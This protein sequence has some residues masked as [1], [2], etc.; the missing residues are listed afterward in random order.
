MARINLTREEYTSGELPPVCVV[1]GEYTE[2]QQSHEF[3]S[4][5]F[6]L[7]L[8]CY[9]APWACWLVPFFC[10]FILLGV[11]QTT[12]AV[13]PVCGDHARYWYRRRLFILFLVTASWLFQIAAM[14]FAGQSPLDC[15][16]V[17]AGI[18]GSVVIFVISFLEVRMERVDEN[19]AVLAGVHPDFVAA[20]ER[21]REEEGEWPGSR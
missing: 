21:M 20:V 5:P 15:R 14:R 19:P 18:G 7:I 13:L 2:E 1:C 8:W 4:V 10:S 16:H 17:W 3:S 6:G 12:L 9:S 11:S